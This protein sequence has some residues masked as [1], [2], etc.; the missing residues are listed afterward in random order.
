MLDIYFTRFFTNT[1][2]SVLWI[3]T[4]ITHCLVT[5][6]SIGVIFYVFNEMNPGEM[7]D[8]L[9][10][11]LSFMLSAVVLLVALMS[12][13]VQRMALELIIVLFRIESNTRYSQE[14]LGKR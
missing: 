6:I 9:G 12:L 14:Q 1:W 4:I 8:T 7:P 10:L 3:T 5:L 13:F 11:L 2:I